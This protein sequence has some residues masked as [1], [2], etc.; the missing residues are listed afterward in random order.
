[1]TSHCTCEINKQMKFTILYSKREETDPDEGPVD[2]F[3]TRFWT[4]RGTTSSH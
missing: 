1:M 2:L 4:L 3:V